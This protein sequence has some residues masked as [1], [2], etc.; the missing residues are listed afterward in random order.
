VDAL[1]VFESSLGVK[2]G[3]ASSGLDLLSGVLIH[4]DVGLAW[5]CGEGNTGKGYDDSGA[6]ESC[7]VDAFEYVR[8]VL[9][10]VEGV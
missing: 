7:M 5:L 3:W 6:A 10:E 9:S 4:E 1:A 8:F 2:N